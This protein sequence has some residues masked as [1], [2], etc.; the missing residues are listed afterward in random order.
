M[1]KI[2][3]VLTALVLLTGCFAAAESAAVPDAEIRTLDMKS[4]PWF[5]S[6]KGNYMDGENA[7]QLWFVDGVHDLPYMDLT[8]WADLMNLIMTDDGNNPGYELKLEFDPDENTVTMVRENNFT[9]VFDF[10]EGT[11][12]YYDFVGFSK[13]FGDFY[14]DPTGIASLNMPEETV[15][16]AITGSRD[17][18]GKYT[19][20]NLKEYGIPMIAQDGKYLL[21]LETLSTLFLFTYEMGVYFNGEAVFLAAVENMENPL[22]ELS[23]HLANEGLVTPEIQALIDAYNG[24]ED[25]RQSYMLELISK[26]SEKGAEVVEIFNQKMKNGLYPV[27][28]AVPSAPRSEALIQFSYNELCMEL[29]CLYGLKESHDIS[30]FDLFFQQTGLVNKLLDP[31]AQIA[32]QGIAE[33][34][35]YWFDDGHSAFCS[36]SW[37]ADNSPDNRTGYSMQG[38][39]RNV[40]TARQIR[41]KYPD[42]S[43]A[44]LEVG[45][46]AYITFDGFDIAPSTNSDAWLP[47]YYQLAEQGKLPQDT[48]GILIQAFRQITREGSPVKNVV[49][50][51]SCNGGGASAAAVYTLCMFL[52]E[53]QISSHNTFTGTQTTVTYK[54]DLNLDHVFDDQDT[55]AGRGLNLYCLISPA[56]FSCGNLVP[57]AFKE[58]GNVTLLGK[59]SGGGSCVVQHMTTAWG[60]SYQISGCSRIAFQK[61]GSYYDVDRGVEPDHIIDTYDHFYDRKALTEYIHGLY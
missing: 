33:L 15:P 7:L 3:A 22:D 13:P 32:D 12:I 11:I 16:I 42:A 8:S 56:S 52:G 50:D 37:M 61:N 49:L 57:W 36:S 44:Y 29:D 9:A 48:F 1:K 6:Q 28:A 14:T 27:Y 60:T 34:M 38:Y 41:A 18:Y 35:S 47:D 51:L 45:D 25:D 20:I 55:L 23:W 58:N 10:S 24:P 30:N 54:A 4:F 40:L 26:S 2:L 53:S 39:D 46:T 59:V 31:N 17:R 21:P 5:A 43:Q 19:V